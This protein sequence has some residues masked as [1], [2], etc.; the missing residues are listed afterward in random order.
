LQR[1]PATNFTQF[2]N[3]NLSYLIG[4]VTDPNNSSA[5]L[6]AD[7]GMPTCPL[8]G[9][10]ITSL[11]HIPPVFPHPW[12]GVHNRLG[13]ILF[14][15]GHVEE[16]HDA[17]VPSEESVAEDLV[18]PSVQGAIENTPLFGSG[19]GGV[20]KHIPTQSVKPGGDTPQ[21]VSASPE[22]SNSGLPNKASAA[23]NSPTPPVNPPNQP[24]NVAYNNQM[25]PMQIQNGRVETQDPSN[26]V[27]MIPTVTNAPVMAP[28]QDE[29]NLMSTFDKH[30]GKTL[31]LIL[32]WSYL[33]LLLLVLL[34]LSFEL[35]RRQRQRKNRKAR[36]KR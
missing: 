4:L 34:L 17:I 21:V 1:W 27:R 29:T 5:I 24:N 32:E 36:L 30:V 13:N 16:S 19:G 3:W 9:Y 31:R 35:W 10:G 6:A 14:A 8:L 7:R 11:R 2:N 25:P 18:Y 23:N 12:E 20:Q 33:L 15:D 28:T 26:A 22:L